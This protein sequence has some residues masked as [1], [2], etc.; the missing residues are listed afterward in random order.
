VGLADRAPR[1]HDLR[2]RPDAG[3]FAPDAPLDLPLAAP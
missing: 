3:E 1:S 2:R